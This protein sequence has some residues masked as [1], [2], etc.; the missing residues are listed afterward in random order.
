MCTSVKMTKQ[1]ANKFCGAHEATIRHQLVG[2]WELISYISRPEDPA[3]EGTYPLG[4]DPKG[5]LLYTAD[6]YM[7]AQIQALESAKKDA[8]S[9]QIA[10]YL[11]Y[12]GPFD[13]DETGSET[14]LQHHMSLSSFPSWLGDTQRR[15]VHLEGDHLVFS[16]GS[17]T[18]I[19]VTLFPIWVG[20]RCSFDTIR[21]RSI[22]PF[23]LGGAW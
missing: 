5:I 11:A 3:E 21:G 8:N 1:T 18:V 10:S 15:L 23:S 20:S 22:G 2:A 6:G 12:T 9:T 7:S 14:V 13:I 19:Q 17:E 4:K 16:V